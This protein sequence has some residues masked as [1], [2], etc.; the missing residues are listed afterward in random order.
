MIRNKPPLSVLRSLA[1]IVRRG[2]S[3]VL[4]G[5][6][7]GYRYLISPLLGDVCRFHPTCSAYA[8]EAVE[9]HG[10]FRGS[11]FAIRRLARCHPFHPG[12]YDPVSKPSHRH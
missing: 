6:I 5:L 7:T 11:W 9:V 1:A 12:G 8:R 2:L 4:I 3:A 10:P